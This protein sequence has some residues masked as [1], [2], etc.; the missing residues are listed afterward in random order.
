MDEIAT[1]EPSPKIEE[2]C[3]HVHVNG[4]FNKE[5]VDRFLRLKSCL[6]IKKQ[7][8]GEKIVDI[9]SQVKVC[10][11]LS[12]EKLELVVKHGKGPELKPTEIIKKV[13]A[14]SDSQM[15][16]IKVLKIKSTI[17]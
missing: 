15:E 14:L 10:N 1:K 11:F 9:R 7:K 17:A 6:V 2:S 8:K 3:F 13:L 5:L 12:H 4:F 16:G